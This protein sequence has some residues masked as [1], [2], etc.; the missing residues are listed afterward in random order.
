MP[1]TAKNARLL[2]HEDKAKVI[3]R[4]PFTI[5]LKTAT[6]ETVQ[7]VTLGVD[8]GSKTIGLSATTEKEEL[9]SA[10]V[11]LRNDIVDLLAA[12]AQFRRAR[13]SRTTRYRKA[14]FLNRKKAEGWLAPSVQNKIDNHLKIVEKV[15]RLLPLA[16]II[17][18]VASFDIQKI[19]KPN[20]SGAQYQQGEQ[21]DFWNVRE[22]V[23]FRDGHQC[24][25]KPGC[26]NKILNVHHVE[27]RKT[28][29]D[30][31]G[32]LITVCEECHKAHHG[33]TLRLNLKRRSESFRDAAFMGI[34]R[35][36]FYNHLKTTHPNVDLTYGYIT[37]N[38]RISK[39]LPKEHRIDAL[40]ISGNAT[41]TRSST[42]Y[43]YK[44][45]RGQN[46]QLHKATIRKCGIRPANKAPRFV[47]GFQLFD[48]VILNKQE[49]FV[50]GRRASGSFDVRLLD[51]TKVHAG[52]N[53]KKLKLV[54]KASTL[55]V[56]IQKQEER[57]SR[58]PPST[59]VEGF[60]LRLL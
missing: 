10:T 21:L 4:T 39:S 37:K 40:C 52:I 5:R 33:G 54:E 11:V 31:P 23:L 29:G 1:T 44:Q 3:Q 53:C 50:F 9:F 30:S 12:R 35:W 16:K 24:Q 13:R 20:I 59:K 56:Q 51:G 26:S 22:Y 42:W 49:C 2:L 32:N 58:L 57:R 25:G 8:A 19:Q 18:E 34:M 6:G 36:S 60:R 14:R 27:S 46:R 45:V 28:G 48:K 55:L 47:K 43:C 38:I 41:A 7:P 15:Q 17:V